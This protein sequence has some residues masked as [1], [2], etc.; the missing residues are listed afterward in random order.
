MNFPAEY[1][2]DYFFAD[3]CA[4]WIRR[5]DVPSNAVVGL[6]HRHQRPGRSEGV[7]RRLPLLPG[8]RLR[9]RLSR[10]LR[11][12]RPG[13]H[14]P[15]GQSH[16][17]A[18]AGGHVLGRGQRHRALHLSVAAQQRRHSGRHRCQLHA[19]ARRSSA[20]TAPA[21]VSTSPTASATSTAT[22][23]CSPSRSTSRRRRRSP[24]RSPARPMRPDRRSPSPVR[25]PTPRT[26]RA[27]P[28]PSAGAST[29]TTTRTRTR[30]C[31]RRAA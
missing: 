4:G 3:F 24:L 8:A 25:A 28:A 9:R 27:R 17:V 11:H 7:E 16:R 6:R 30:S 26:A 22:R 10:A 18:G 2:N 15:S 14:H 13:H 1:L 12:R 5:I 19:D 31:R 23:P 29:S 20:T 21:F